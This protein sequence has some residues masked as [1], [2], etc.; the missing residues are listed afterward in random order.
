MNLNEA[1]GRLLVGAMQT[2]QSA[3]LESVTEA[4]SLLE[5][6]Q[7]RYGIKTLD[8]FWDEEVAVTGPA[9]TTTEEQV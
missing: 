8:N 6:Y 1:I 7:E 2:N 5:M 3:A 9:E 4:V